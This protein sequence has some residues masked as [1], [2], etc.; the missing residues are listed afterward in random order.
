MVGFL[1]VSH[2]DL[3]LILALNG[4][5]MAEVISHYGQLPESLFVTRYRKIGQNVAHTIIGYV[6][7]LLLLLILIE[8]NF[9][10]HKIKL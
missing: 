8:K 1:R 5:Q 2:N 9:F 3:L 7:F 4:Q 10:L 6:V